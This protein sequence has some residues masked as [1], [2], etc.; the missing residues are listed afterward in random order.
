MASSAHAGGAADMRA[1]APVLCAVL[2]LAGAGPATAQSV[3]D[4]IRALVEA[5]IWAELGPPVLLPG[6]GEAVAFRVLKSFELPSL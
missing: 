5:G 4:E 3:A 1:T 6:G 2:L